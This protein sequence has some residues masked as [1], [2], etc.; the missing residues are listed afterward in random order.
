VRINSR[1]ESTGDKPEN[2][3]LAV[4]QG[5]ICLGLLHR[6]PDEA[7]GEAFDSIVGI[8]RWYL[9][10]PESKAPAALPQTISCRVL[11]PVDEAPFVLDEE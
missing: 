8:Y 6:L 2:L 7:R 4:V 5:L 11:A 10:R 1:L 3:P 9:E